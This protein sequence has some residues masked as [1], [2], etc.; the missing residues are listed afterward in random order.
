MDTS[1]KEF[2]DNLEYQSLKS[3]FCPTKINEISLHLGDEKRTP[4]RYVGKESDILLT[5]VYNAIL[6]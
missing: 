3:N 1:Q 6:K 5:R 4:T 2:N